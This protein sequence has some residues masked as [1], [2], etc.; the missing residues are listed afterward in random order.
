LLVRFLNRV[1][2]NGTYYFGDMDIDKELAGEFLADGYVISLEEPEVA[3]V[4]AGTQKEVT[5][6]EIKTMKRGPLLKLCTSRNI[7]VDFSMTSEHL[8]KLLGV[9][10]DGSND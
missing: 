8:R 5:I 9:E 1:K 7:K 4:M 3:F 6:E 2:R 10:P